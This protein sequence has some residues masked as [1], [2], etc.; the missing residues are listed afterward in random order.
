MLPFLFSC[1]S[2]TSLE[3]NSFSWKEVEALYM[4]NDDAGIRR[5]NFVNVTE[6][7]LNNPQDALKTA[8]KEH[9]LQVNESYSVFY[10]KSADMWKVSFY[11]KDNN[12][13]SGS[14]DV[15]LNGNGITRL[16]VAGE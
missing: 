3:A 14:V 7:K 10:D 6:S 16:I 5:D 2:K 1:G 12:V 15:Y 13:V 11:P 8:R 4:N 9:E